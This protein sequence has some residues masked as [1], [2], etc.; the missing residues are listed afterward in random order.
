MIG[1]MIGMFRQYENKPMHLDH[2]IEY[3]SPWIPYMRRKEGG[4]YTGNMKS[5]V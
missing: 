3:M 1:F 2:I 5:S 4:R